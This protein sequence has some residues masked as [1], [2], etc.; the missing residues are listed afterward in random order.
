MKSNPA[1]RIVPSLIVAGAF[2]AQVLELPAQSND[3]LL[4]KLVEKGVLNTQEAAALKKEVDAGSDKADRTRTGLPEWVTALKIYGDLR[5]RYEFFHTD[6]D[7]PGALEPNK[8]RS[9]FRHWRLRTTAGCSR[10]PRRTGRS[11]CGTCRRGGSS[12]P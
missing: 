6:N 12:A 10:A 4:N 7:T 11:Q 2:G 9:R 8:D 1:K 3:A 5:A